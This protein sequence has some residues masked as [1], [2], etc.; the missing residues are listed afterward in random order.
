MARR[1]VR[2]TAVTEPTNYL[3]PWLDK[4]GLAHHLACSVRWIERRMEDGMPHTHIAGRAKFR[5]SEV[6]PW[7]ERHG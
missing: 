6:E 2:S 4:R 5:V 3:E 7:L 1:A